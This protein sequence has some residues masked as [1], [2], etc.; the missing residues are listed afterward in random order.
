MKKYNILN[1]NTNKIK[2]I[3]ENKHNILQKHCK[4]VQ[5]TS[6]F[7]FVKIVVSKIINIKARE[8]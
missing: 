1:G 3:N 4:I 6:S 8:N 2:I 7:L 5:Y